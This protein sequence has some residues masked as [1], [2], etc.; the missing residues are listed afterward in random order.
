MCFFFHW[1]QLSLVVSIHLLRKYKK[2]LRINLES[3][4]LYDCAAMDSNHDSGFHPGVL[5][6]SPGTCY[7]HWPEYAMPRMCVKRYWV[8]EGRLSSLCYPCG[9]SA[10]NCHSSNCGLGS[11]CVHR[12]TDIV[13]FLVPLSFSPILFS[14]DLL[15]FKNTIYFVRCYCGCYALLFNSNKKSRL[16]SDFF[17]S[18]RQ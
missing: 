10:T 12:Q 16:S 2:A 3:C 9:S 14:H 11:Y 6:R 13:W 8:K 4:C 5:S 7:L 15:Q 17:F 1:V 18:F